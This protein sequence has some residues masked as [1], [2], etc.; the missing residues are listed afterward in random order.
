MNNKDILDLIER[1][2]LAKIGEYQ[3]W[4]KIIKKINCDEALDDEDS[5]YFSTLT[6]IYKDFKISERS[7]IYHTKLS[8]E[9]SKLPCKTC[10]EESLFYCNMNDAY[11][12]Q[13]HVVGHDENE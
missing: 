1:M 2:K 12:C 13:V 7:K 10:G 8:K 11:F 5:K 6:R 3:R 4:K 9:D